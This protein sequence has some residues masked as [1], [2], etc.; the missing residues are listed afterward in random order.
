MKVDILAIGVHPDDIELGCA[1]T[2]LRH[3]AQGCSIG[4]LDLTRGE[5]GSR[6][7][8]VIRTAEAAASAKLLG[9]KFRENA[10]M[11]DGFFQHTEENLRKIIRV[12]RMAQ[13][14]IVLANALRDRHPDHGRAAKLIADACYYSGLVKIVTHNNQGQE[15]EKWRPKAVYHYS[16]DNNYRPDFVVDITDYF[17]QKMAAILCYSSQFHAPS[18]EEYAQEPS[19]PISGKD[20]LDYQ[21]AKAAAFGREAGYLLAEAFQ[22]ERMI[23]VGDLRQLD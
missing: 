4:L 16:Q 1:G 13:P 23:G 5:L 17:E 18:A 8:A 21:R 3:Q 7:S 9:A 11:A 19:T 6:G 2:L 12:I 15:Q 22:V 14:E 20:F 10:D